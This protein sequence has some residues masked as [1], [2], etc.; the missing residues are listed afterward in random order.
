MGGMTNVI[1]IA[2]LETHASGYVAR[3]AA[4]EVLTVA[5]GGRPVARLVPVHDSSLRAALDA[6]LARAARRPVADL[7]LPR[8]A[9]VPS[10]LWAALD[11]ERF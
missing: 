1:E 7:P 4:G 2:E 3:A 10:A 8:E 11:D 6:G 9:D 5:D